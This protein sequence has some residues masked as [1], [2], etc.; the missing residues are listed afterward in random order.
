MQPHRTKH[1]I[2]NTQIIII[3]ATTQR[4]SMQQHT[5]QQNKAATQI[6]TKQQ[7]A[8]LQHATV[9]NK[10]AM[11][12]QA[13]GSSNPRESTFRQFQVKNQ[14]IMQNYSES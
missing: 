4:H 9:H 13:K 5:T 8:T 10:S 2:H 3:R 12:S 11:Q 1:H 7:R 6:E 14:G